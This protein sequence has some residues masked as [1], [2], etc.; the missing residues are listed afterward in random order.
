[1]VG[2]L[3][4]AYT[5][6]CNVTRLFITRYILVGEILNQGKPTWFLIYLFFIQ[7][8]G[9]KQCVQ[10][11]LYTSQTPLCYKLTTSACRCDLYI[12]LEFLYHT[13]AE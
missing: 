6:P 10:C 3:R 1:M 11:D 7:L 2:C 5:A 4:S 9:H 8:S 12:F 13:P